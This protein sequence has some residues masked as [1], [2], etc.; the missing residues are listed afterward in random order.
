MFNK[1]NDYE[2]IEWHEYTV[3]EPDIDELGVR[4]WRKFSGYVALQCV[5]D[6]HCGDH[7]RNSCL[8]VIFLEI[9][10]GLK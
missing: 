7:Q 1:N 3:K 8:K 4:C 6:K 2:G 5:D 10:S 9:N